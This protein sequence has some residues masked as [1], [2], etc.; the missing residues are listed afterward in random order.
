M[1]R[2]STTFGIRAS[3]SGLFQWL[4]ERR[5]RQYTRLHQIPGVIY[6]SFLDF[7]FFMNIAIH[8]FIFQY[9]ASE[10]NDLNPWLT[11]GRP[12]AQERRVKLS[13]LCSLYYY[14]DHNQ[15]TFSVFVYYYTNH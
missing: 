15:L 6:L 13:T 3:G 8:D 10:R 14:Y 5:I 7:I 9:F 11:H 2:I 4:V 12:F 1:E